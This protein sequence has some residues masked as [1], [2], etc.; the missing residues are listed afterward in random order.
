MKKFL[1]IA[2]ISF[3]F[4]FTLVPI[5]LFS[6]DDDVDGPKSVV[7]FNFAGPEK[8]AARGEED[9]SPLS[10]ILPVSLKSELDKSGA[11]TVTLGG[12]N[13]ALI[14]GDDSDMIELLKKEAENQ[15]AQ[16]VV[17]GR[18]S[19][20]RGN[21]RIESFI[22]TVRGNKILPVVYEKKKVGALFDTIVTELS[23]QI[24]REMDTYTIKRTA[25]PTIDPAE[26]SFELP[27]VITINGSS[28]DEIYYTLDGS[29]PT[30][31]DGDL[32]EGPFTLRRSAVVS[33]SAYREG[34]FI[35]K[36]VSRSIEVQK[37]VSYFTL[38]VYGGNAV[39]FGKWRDRVSKE[40]L[41]WFSVFTQWEFANIAS[42]ESNVFLKNFGITAAFH[43]G[44]T[45]IEN[46][47]SSG[48]TT[49]YTKSPSLASGTESTN[50][51]TGP[52][53]GYIFGGSLGLF[54]VYRPSDFFTITAEITGGYVRITNNE[55]DDSGMKGTF[56]LPQGNQVWKENSYTTA[57]TMRLQYCWTHFIIHGNGEYRV[58]RIPDEKEFMKM[59][60][61]GVG[62]GWKF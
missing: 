47:P 4:A 27:P 57:G 39:V 15:S 54:T 50:S 49:T 41:S 26:E 12:D 20:P 22:Y 35:S 5:P 24:A 34:S 45:S 55:G 3:T 9:F 6:A 25:A 18:F 42:P 36:P 61:F 59:F 23:S 7:V 13:P 53:R 16:F 33:A 44:S 8:K 51:Y 30:K 52:M 2:L 37:P 40:G 10:T 38:G 46:G 62:V 11:F 58:V 1:Q 43:S 21:L 31:E 48:P 28:A 29:E 32:Y 17:V 60:V 14:E 19:V 56:N